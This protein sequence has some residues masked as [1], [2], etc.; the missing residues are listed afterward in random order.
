MKDKILT[1]AI[2]EQFL[3]GKIKDLESFTSIEA[4]AAKAL[5][6]FKG[7]WIKLNG[8]TSL[9]TQA[10]K[11]LASFEGCLDLNGLT[12]LSDETAKALASFQ[13]ESLR[14]DGL[15]SL[16]DEAAKALAAFKGTKGTLLSLNGLKELNLPESKEARIQVEDHHDVG[17]YPVSELD[18]CIARFVK[19]IK[20]FPEKSSTMVWAKHNEDFISDSFIRAAAKL[21]F[22]EKELVEIDYA[23]IPDKI[24]ADAFVL[25]KIH[26]RSLTA[27]KLRQLLL[28]ET[29]DVLSEVFRRSDQPVLIHLKALH[30]ADPSIKNLLDILVE[31]QFRP[32]CRDRSG[33][34]HVVL[35]AL[36][37]VNR[38]I[39][40]QI[41]TPHLLTRIISMFGFIV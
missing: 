22:P 33:T 39:I 30:L 29:E 8:L 9:S 37:D 27:Q 2:A 35:S 4:E 15:T 34:T 28:Y 16:S 24:S 21:L 17:Y 7:S 26:S 41:L 5:A 25:L 14:L 12:S 10:A 1:K 32:I 6:T 13:V 3:A 38:D 31:G 18:R 19:T 11:A 40:K 20:Q 36:V 23:K